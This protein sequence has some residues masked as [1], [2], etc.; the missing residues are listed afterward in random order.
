MH[1]IYKI[2]IYQ[3]YL[4]KLEK[5]ETQHGKKVIKIEQSIQDLVNS[6][7]FN[8]CVFRI[9]E[10]KEREWARRNIWKDNGKHFS[11]IDGKHQIKYP[12][13]TVNLKQEQYKENNVLKQIAVKML[14]TQDKE[15][16]L[17]AARGNLI[18][19]REQW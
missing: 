8:I 2:I 5:K 6:K 17:T 12:K 18:V 16:I 15:I 11:K 7:R 1:W 19:W 10:E 14:K 4:I 3:L 9:Q 13:S